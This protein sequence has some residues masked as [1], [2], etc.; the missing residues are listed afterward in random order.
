MNKIKILILILMVFLLSGCWDYVGLNKITTV[1]GIAIDKNEKDNK[2]ELTFEYVNLAASAKTKSI[3]TKIIEAK[4]STVFEALRNAKK[5]VRNKLYLPQAQVIIINNK[6][7]KED[8]IY[9][10]LNF[11]FR[12]VEIRETINVII[13]DEKNAKDI[14]KVKNIDSTAT[15]YEIQEI[16]VNDNNV[17]SSTKGNM[18]YEIY[19]TLNNKSESLALPLFHIIKNANKKAI[20]TNGIAIFKKDKV[21]GNLN[22]FDS[23]YYLFIDDS[24]KGGIIP[25]KYKNKDYNVSLEIDKN[26]T[27]KTYKKD[28]NK[29]KFMININTSMYLAE[30]QDQTHDLTQKD[31]DGI[32]KEGEKTI[33]KNIEKL[34]KKAKKTYKHDIFSLGNLV[35]NKDAKLWSKVKKKWDKLF[36]DAD[37]DVKVNVE[38][39]SSE[40]VK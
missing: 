39:T 19:N 9:N 28:D 10:I 26:V 17:T 30:Y 12:D 4:G 20:E 1:L 32:K 3:D 33:K 38:I 29:F 40:M 24:I 16:V 7:A 21:I 34:I 2:Y 27:R 5:R 15:S 23:K 31:L 35:A 8:G 13:S 37:I 22:A 11:F 25:I 18:L 6:V 14:L 36:L